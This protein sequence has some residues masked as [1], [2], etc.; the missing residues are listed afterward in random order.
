M[1]MRGRACDPK[2]GVCG[3]G[4][5]LNDRRYRPGIWRL[6]SFQKTTAFLAPVLR[7][8]RLAV[9]WDWE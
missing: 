9:R 3:F 6:E 2:R 4:N 8:P 5:K 7:S 1:N